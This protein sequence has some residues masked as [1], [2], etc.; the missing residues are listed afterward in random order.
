MA[1]GITDF[2]SR[3]FGHR[4]NR[5]IINGSFPEAVAQGN[6]S[7]AGAGAGLHFDVYCKATQVPGSSIGVIPIAWQGRT[8]KFSSERTYADWTI[9]IYDSSIK[10]QNLRLLFEDWINKMNH[11]TDHTLDYSLTSNWQVSFNDVS[12]SL[13]STPQS[14]HQETYTLYNCFPI[15]ISPIDLSYDM[16]D[17]F[18]EITVTL[19]YDYWAPDGAAN[20]GN[21]TVAPLPFSERAG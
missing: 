4:P 13:A 16:A 20:A 2:R 1:T 9:Q 17:S 12:Q 14:S 3:F 19:A 18:A 7:T 10:G 21:A 6:N 11:R 5:F 8:V 15:D